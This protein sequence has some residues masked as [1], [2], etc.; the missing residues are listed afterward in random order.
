MESLTVGQGVFNLVLWG[1]IVLILRPA[2]KF[3]HKLK[4]ARKVWGI[5]LIL[6]FCLFPF[7]GGDYFHYEDIWNETRQGG[8]SSLEPVYIWLIGYTGSYFVFRLIVW[9]LSLL[10]LFGTYKRVGYS[11]DLSLFIF[12]TLYMPWFSYARASLAMSCILFGL[13]FLSKPLKRANLFSIL[14]GLAIVGCSEFFHRSALLGI[15]AVVASLL[16]VDNKRN[17]ILILFL[18]YPVII[19]LMSYVLDIT[20]TLDLDNDTYITAKRRDNYLLG[21]RNIGGWGERLEAYLNQ[22]ALIIVAVAYI[23]LVRKGLYQS[24]NRLEKLISSYSL[25]VVLLAVG[26]LI[27][28]SDYSTYILYY[29]LL[30]FSAPATAVFLASMKGRYFLKRW[31]NV[32]FWMAFCGTLYALLYAIHC[33]TH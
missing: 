27:T 8:Y 16:V 13:T 1:I 32:I 23:V 18:L 31:Y 2:L 28:K 3:P 25:C 11:F 10:L 17:R 12:A 33:A 19:Y 22:G 21:E 4:K 29:R 20:M 6:L 30:L 7:W 15:V 14:I 26:F 24:L 5:I 9:G